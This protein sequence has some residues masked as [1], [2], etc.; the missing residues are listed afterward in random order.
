MSTLIESRACPKCSTSGEGTSLAVYENGTHCFECGDTQRT[1]GESM[2]PIVKKKT[3][4]MIPIGKYQAIKSRGISLKTAELYKC[5]VSEY[6]G[7]KVMCQSFYLGGAVVAQK[8][9]LRKDP[10]NPKKPKCMWLGDKSK[11]PPLWGMDIWEPNPKLSVVICEGEPDMLCRSSLNDNKWPVLS[12]LDGAGGQSI[13]NLAKAKEYLLGF[14][15]IILMFD[16]DTA[17]R[18]AAEAAVE[19]LGPTAKI[20][21]MPEGEDVCSLVEKGRGDEIGML[22]VRAAGHRPKDIVTVDD[23][24]EE[25]LYT[26]EGR[27]IPTP[28]PKL[29]N[30]LRGLKHASL[31]MF[32]A[33]SGL[34]KSTIVKE[35]AYD[36]MYNKG[37]KVGCIFLEQ[38]DK[39][40]MKD[41][42][43]MDN[44]MEA[45]EFNQNPDLIEPAAR[46]ASRAT[47]AKMGVFYKHFGS[48]DST[49]LVSKIE[50]MMMGCD[51]DFVILDHISMAISGS[52]S[53]QG[54]RKDIDV[55]MT[56]LVTLIHSTGKSVIAV[57]HLK[58]PPGEVKDY[59]NGGK[60]HISS[61][62][63]SA[64]LEQMSDYI[65]ALERN[66]FSPERSDQVQLKVLKCRR[67]GKVGYADV[68]QYSHDTGR[69]SVL[70]EDELDDE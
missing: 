61:L 33:G 67:G 11:V 44:N 63:G 66:Q 45:E 37:I 13:K 10:N 70:C 32:C 34:G 12:L 20:A 36:L 54:E 64:A 49:T 60:V 6:K 41:Y 5:T 21:Q 1:S 7:E 48:L 69:L 50:Y 22:E 47:L 43:A 9:K 51:C 30:L 62:R 26:V 31:Y 56:N 24:T 23:Y 4:P 17:G 55:L 3:K 46:E 2:E 59:N 57:S 65:I 27:G 58:R 14:K 42:I 68:L 53:S 8:I 38:G 25:E 35:I 28:F 52:T 19:L 39:E 18:A 16:G 40:A 29:T 15:R